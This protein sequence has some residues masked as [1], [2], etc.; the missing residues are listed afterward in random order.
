MIRRSA[1]IQ[2]VSE[3][4]SSQD[5]TRLT[6]VESPDEG[7]KEAAVDAGFS[8]A[9]K[10]RPASTSSVDENM[11]FENIP[12]PEKHL[13]ENPFESSP[14][15]KFNTKSNSKN[16]RTSA[17][18]SG[19]P[20]SKKTKFQ[21]LEDLESAAVD[22][23]GNLSIENEEGGDLG[24]KNRITPSR[25]E[26]TATRKLRLRVKDSP[27]ASGRKKQVSKKA[28][29]EERLELEEDSMPALE[30]IPDP[31]LVTVASSNDTAHLNSTVDRLGSLSI[32]NENQL[33]P[34]ATNSV[35]KTPAKP[36]SPILSQNISNLD[37]NSNLEEEDAPSVMRKQ[38]KTSIL[39]KTPNKRKR[40]PKKASDKK[41]EKND[42]VVVVRNVPKLTWSSLDST[43][44]EDDG[45]PVS[46]IPRANKG[47]FAEIL[48]VLKSSL[49]SKKY[50][51]ER[52]YH[53]FGFL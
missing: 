20:E 19:T 26:N 39:N 22:R 36:P 10:K 42:P 21:F 7:E 34:K 11:S 27:K 41:N 14:T 3:N 43:D 46:G 48:T 28:T 29:D 23:F 30:A 53:H 49:L 24:K 40:T 31:E 52:R 9:T 38:R 17:R 2:K 18:Q 33:S 50:L 25:R 37:P 47:N 45:A 32:E 51:P 16:R 35:N 12:I 13:S 5:S 6:I 44:D 1:R 4:D 8:G 15:R